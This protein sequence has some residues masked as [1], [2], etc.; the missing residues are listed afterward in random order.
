MFGRVTIR[1]GIGPHSSLILFFEAIRSIHIHMKL[2]VG[3]GLSHEFALDK[4]CL[5][6]STNFKYVENVRSS[7]VVECECELRHIS[8]GN[9]LYFYDL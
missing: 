1:L 8:N 4:R 2:L 9:I 7:N 5:K 6:H 3:Q